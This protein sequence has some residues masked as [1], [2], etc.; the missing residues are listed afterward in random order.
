VIARLRARLL[1]Q[2][3]PPLVVSASYKQHVFDERSAA[4]NEIEV[5]E[6]EAFAIVVVLGGLPSEEFVCRVWH[7]Y[8]DEVWLVDV[9]EQAV[10]IVPRDGAIRVFA[11][12]D[13]LRST[14]LPGIAIPVAQLFE[15]A[16]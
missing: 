5:R 11:T 2:V 3:A 9:V 6:G 8:A 13:T 10:S 12:G 7:R 14:R 1:L 15:L 16:S 4:Y